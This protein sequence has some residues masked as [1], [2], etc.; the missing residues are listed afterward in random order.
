MIKLKF[1]RMKKSL[2]ILLT[3]FFLISVTASAV[4][5][6]SG[7]SGMGGGHGGSGMGGG[8]GGSG[9]GGG[10]GGSGMGGGH[11]GS[12]MGGGN[13]NVVV[14]NYV[15][16]NVYVNVIN[17]GNVGNTNVDVGVGVNVNNHINQY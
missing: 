12:G 11:G 5:A 8:H 3:V 7:G 10:H 9:M 17:I 16:T 14:N 1:N 13:K 15:V 6:R 2:V 4:S